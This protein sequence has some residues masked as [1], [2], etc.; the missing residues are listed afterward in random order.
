MNLLRTGVFPL[1]MMVAACSPQA[2]PGR[3]DGDLPGEPSRAESPTAVPDS[4]DW[5]VSVEGSG[6][7]RIGMTLA[8]AAPYL[9]ADIDTTTLRR[10]CDYVRGAEAPDSMLFMIEG[11]RLAR[12]DVT[13]GAAATPEGARVGDAESRILSLYPSASRGPHKYTDGAYLTVSG[14]DDSTS[15]YVF[16]TDGQRVTRYRAGVVPAVEYVEGCS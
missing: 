11:G 5:T 15:R 1:L 13:G 7:F 14:A 3:A 4:G 6:P 8:E 12:I 16:E 10:E 9:A 2:D